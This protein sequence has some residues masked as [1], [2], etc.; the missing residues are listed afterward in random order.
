MKRS[1]YYQ[2]YVLF[3][4]LLLSGCSFA[5]SETSANHLT[6]VSWN[7]QNLFDGTDNGFEYDEFK[8]GTGWNS[9]KYQARLQ[10]ITAALKGDS[11]LNPDILALIEVENEGVILDL[12]DSSC[13]NYKWS[14]FAGTPVYPAD[15]WQDDDSFQSVPIGMGVLSAL[16]FIETR[17][18]SFHLE[19]SSIPRPVAEVWVDTGSGPLVLLVCHWKSKLGGEKKTESLRRAGSALI[20]RRLAEIEAERAGTPVIILGD[21]NEN[22]DEFSRIGAA[23]PCALLPDTE[24]AAALIQKAPAGVRSDFRDFLVLSREKPPKPNFF[25]ASGTSVYSPWYELEEGLLETQSNSAGSYYYKDEWETI[26]HFLLNSALF[27]GHELS[28]GYFRVLSEPPFANAAGHP[29]TYNPRTGNGL[30]DHL[31]IVL[32]LNKRQ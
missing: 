28:Y 18:H 13:L 7:V 1:F 3:L 22:Y 29:N 2:V 5:Q 16:P 12:A 23:Y 14:F 11:R 10:S 32:I 27:N 9:E 15:T 4:I 17:V 31:P 20:A 30:S 25:T 6:I 24:E 26:D 8:N 21:L 19:N